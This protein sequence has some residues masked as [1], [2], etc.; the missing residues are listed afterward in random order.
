MVA[1]QFLVHGHY[2]KWS[3]Q[4]R[5]IRAIHQFVHMGVLTMP[6]TAITQLG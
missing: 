3:L 4:G 2:A 5:G 1:V 6:I